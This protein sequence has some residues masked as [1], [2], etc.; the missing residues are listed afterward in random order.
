MAKTRITDLQLDLWGAPSPSVAQEP[1]TLNTEQNNDGNQTTDTHDRGLDDNRRAAVAGSEIHQPL[2]QGRDPSEEVSTEGDSPASTGETTGS[3]AAGADEDLLGELED[4]ETERID[5]GASTGSGAADYPGPGRER[6]T[7]SDPATRPPDPEPEFQPRNLRNHRIAD[8]RVDN[9][10]TTS[11]A[12]AKIKANLDALELMKQIESEERAPTPQEQTLLAGYVDFG[13]LRQMWDQS[14]NFR[15]EHKRMES[16]LTEEEI[17]AIKETS[18]NTHYT[19]LPVVDRIWEASQHLGFDGGRILEPGMGIGNFFGRLPNTISARSELLGIEKNILSGRM[20]RMLYPD[21]NIIVKPYEQ[22]QIPNNSVD[23][24][25]GNP[26]FAEIKVFD[27][28]YSNPKFSVHNYFIVK[29]LDK[30]RANGIATLITSHYTLDSTNTRAREAMFERADLVGAIRLPE[31]T[32]AKNAGTRVTTDILFFRKREAGEEPSPLNQRFIDTVDVPTVDE[33]EAV[34]INEYFRDHPEMVLGQHSSRNGMYGSTQY[35]LLPNGNLGQQLTAAIDRLPS[36]ITSRQ[37]KAPQKNNRERALESAD[38]A[39]DAVKESAFYIEDGKVWIKERGAKTPLPPKLSKPATVYQLKSL[40]GLREALKDTL[41]IQ[42]TE[43]GDESL[44]KAQSILSQKYDSYRAN[45]GSLNAPKTARLFADDPEYPLLTALENIDPETQAITRAA[46]FTARTTRPYQPLHELPD[47]PKAAMLKVLAQEGHLNLELMSSLLKLDRAKVIASLTEKGL[48]FRDPVSGDYQ[49]ADEYLSGNVRL[50]LAQATSAAAFDPTF[51]P[52]VEALTEVQP[53]PVSI[54]DIELRLGQTWIP[55]RLYSNFIGDVLSNGAYNRDNPT[56]TRDLDGRWYVDLPQGYN[57]F[58]LDHQW[59]GGTVP[60][61]KLVEYALNQQQP[62]VYF[63]P[64]PD[65]KREIDT[66]NTAA[67]RAKLQE[68]KDSFS[69]WVKS[70]KLANEHPELERTYNELFNGVRLRV[71]DGSHLEYP[72]MNPTLEMRPYQ[73]NTTWRIMQ[74]GSA[75]IDHF[76]GAGKT[77]TMIA[78]GMELRRIGLSNKNMYVVPNNAVPQ[79]RQAFKDAYPAANVLAVTDQDLSNSH[80]RK[81]LFSRIAMNDWD[82]AII[83]HSQFN[84]LP[85]SPEREQMTVAKQ[86]AEL[87]ELLED[88]STTSVRGSDRAEHRTLRRLQIKKQNY[89]ERLKELASGRKDNTIYFDDL[90][91]D[92]LF[93]DEAHAYKALPFVTK[94]GNISGLSTRQSQR[95][96]NV[97]AKIDYMYDTHN[98]RGVVFA[99]GTPI[100]NT[101]GEQFTMTRYIAPD[102]LEKSGIRNFDDWAANFAEAVT[103]MEYATDGS[104]IR[105]KTALAQ[106]VNVPELQQIWS[107]FAD[108]MTQEEAVAAGYIKIPKPLRE[109]VLVKVT[110]EQEPLLLEIAARGERLMLPRSDPRHPDPKEDNWLKLDGDARDISLDARFYDRNAKDDPDNKVN[111]AARIAKDVL[112][113]TDEARG[114]VV[115]FADRY[116][117]SDGSFNMFAEVKAK[118]V[119]QGVPENQIAIIHD[120]P[121]R[122]QFAALQHAMCNG[123]VRVTLATTE[124]FGIGVNVQTRLKAEIHMDLPQRPDQVE[125]REG[126]I[127]RYGNTFDEVEIYRLISEPRDVNSPKAHDLQ[128]AQ[129]LERKQTFLTQFKTGSHL[130]RRLED[131][132][133]DVR[134]SPQMFALAKA[135]ATGNPLAMEKIKLEHEIKQISLLERSHKLAHSQNL[136]ELSRAEISQAYLKT[137]LP[138][139]I[140]THETFQQHEH[141]DAEGKLLSMKIVFDGREFSQLKDA[142]EHLK[143]NPMLSTTSSLQVNT[144]DIPIDLA[145]KNVRQGD[146]YQDEIVVSYQFAGEWHDGPRGE[147]TTTAQSLLSSVLARSQRLPALITTTTEK[148][149]AERDRIQRL[150]L[151]LEKQSPYTVKIQQFETRLHEVEKEL[152]KD[153]KEIEEIGDS[154]DDTLEQPVVTVAATAAIEQVA[155]TAKEEIQQQKDSVALPRRLG[156]PQ[157]LPPTFAPHVA[158]T[159]PI[160]APAIVHIAVRLTEEQTKLLLSAKYPDNTRQQISALNSIYTGS[161]PVNVMNDTIA[162]DYSD[163]QKSFFATLDKDLK[164]TLDQALTQLQAE[165]QIPQKQQAPTAARPQGHHHTKHNIERD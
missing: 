64:D 82:A 34:R 150:H 33:G 15:E 52:N 1:A 63:P 132:A 84:M 106:Y 38:F 115:I 27:K 145:Q 165:K 98:G 105:P 2:R 148:L 51:A 57:S 90:G 7:V 137:F 53:A 9:A 133:G 91:V 6:A 60:G 72:G 143:A 39:P 68:I 107:Q 162:L 134:L 160:P 61:H 28:D 154:N 11:G 50:K 44:Q 32:F 139:V 71:F 136:Q 85:I 157:L 66:V 48:I 152:L 70:D 4:R 80:N 164:P 36:D 120:Y 83:P 146:F 102:L 8:T 112:D 77:N 79:W 123:T 129:L 10:E 75:L 21:A 37:V 88:K 18:I 19:A 87:D 58:A 74:T 141:R 128:R 55:S 103:R 125:Q 113:R 62:T 69:D 114:T 30:L 78:A 76:V 101:L 22:V 156:S 26:P 151:E 3:D 159:K 122:E 119:D 54:V 96:Q 104:T 67:A 43:T 142:Y 94:M 47:D 149:A 31:D 59:S 65:G 111:A 97:L 23:L 92:C 100:T 24:I 56:I 35:T 163:A 155:G 95:A 130:G 110:P 42:L 140:Q 25:I 108:V 121:K 93:I 14:W 29:S 147:G 73:G 131:V 49:P 46:I 45:F 118:L 124:K 126:R 41:R 5:F 99:T 89:Q 17:E 138:K 161:A 40:I 86:I 13:G 20:A 16:L 109:D 153:V 117:T 127:I 135:Q 158:V 12:K 81:R 116:A 144:V